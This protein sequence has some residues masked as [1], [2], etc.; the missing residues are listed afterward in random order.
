VTI[1]GDAANRDAAIAFVRF[2]LGPEG[3]FLIEDCFVEPIS[4]ALCPDPDLLPAAL[5]ELVEQ[6]EDL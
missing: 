4:P 2:M 5:R 3:M 6:G 1:L